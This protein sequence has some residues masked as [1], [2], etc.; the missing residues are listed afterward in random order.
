MAEVKMT[1]LIMDGKAGTAARWM[2]MTQGEAAP[3]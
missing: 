3:A 1:A 2:A